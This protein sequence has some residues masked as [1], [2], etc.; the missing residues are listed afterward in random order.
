MPDMIIITVKEFED[1]YDFLLNNRAS[2]HVFYEIRQDK[3]DMIVDK[4]VYFTFLGSHG[5]F[6]VLYQY[7]IEIPQKIDYKDFINEIK[8]KLNII[9]IKFIEGTIREL[10][11]S[12]S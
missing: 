3:H 7:S 11:L 6:S 10:Y 2:D 1:F 9:E 5:N 12:L 8:E 4:L